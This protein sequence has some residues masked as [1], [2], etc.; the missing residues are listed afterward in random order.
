MPPSSGRLAWMRAPSHACPDCLLV[1]PERVP[2]ASQTWRKKSSAL[3]AQS[4]QRTSAREIQYGREKLQLALIELVPRCER[5]EIHNEW[6][7]TIAILSRERGLREGEAAPN[8]RGA[9]TDEHELGGTGRSC[10]RGYRFVWQKVCRNDAERI[11]A[12]EAD[13]FQPR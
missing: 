2:S 7:A 5:N 3:L 1:L 9:S 6:L 4:G 13:H 11:S 10:H 12:A 8:G